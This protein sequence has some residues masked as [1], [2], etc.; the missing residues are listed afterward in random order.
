M[1]GDAPPHVTLALDTATPFLTLAVSWETGHVTAVREVGRAHAEE[2]PGAARAL[3]AQAGLPFHAQTIVIGT[4]P[5]SYTGVRVGASYA[6]GLA[7]VWGARVVGVSTLEALVSG[8]GPQGVSLDARKGHVYGAV[9]DVQGGTVTGTRAAPA[10]ATLE[11]FTA[12]LGTL[13]HR[14]D[15]PPDGMA[16]LRAGQAHGAEDWALAYL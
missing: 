13:P 3:F 14:H 10:K 9:Y 6:L 1:T 11:D 4:G 2:L 12:Q 16:L 15:V 7:A 5:G 8:D